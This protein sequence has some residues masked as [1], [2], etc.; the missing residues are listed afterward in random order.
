MRSG[1][2]NNIF[3]N[4]PI[5]TSDT[6]LNEEKEVSYAESDEF[7]SQSGNVILDSRVNT[8]IISFDAE[9]VEEEKENIHI[10]SH[11]V[12]TI[13]AVNILGSITRRPQLTLGLFALRPI[14]NTI[15][16]S[17]NYQDA[18]PEEPDGLEEE[19]D[20]P[21][22]QLSLTLPSASRY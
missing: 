12:N 1:S 13:I 15:I 18:K 22:A 16:F 10:S 6:I 7:N 5:N 14:A 8:E 2:D 4:I 21:P 20:A 17:N 3:R 11:A 19:L 9:I